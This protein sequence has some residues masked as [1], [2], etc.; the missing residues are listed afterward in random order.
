MWQN[1]P[2]ELKAYIVSRLPL[3]NTKL[4]LRLVSKEWLDILSCS[5]AHEE[6]HQGKEESG[7]R[8]KLPFT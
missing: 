1:L 6:S 4:A 2:F 3:S 8:A 5:A 7:V